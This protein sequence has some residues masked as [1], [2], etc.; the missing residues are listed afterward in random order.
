MKHRVLLSAAGLC[1]AVHSCTELPLPDGNGTVEIILRSPSAGTDTK[2]EDPS[3]DGITDANVF[4][5]NREE[6]LESSTYLSPG[7]FRYKDGEAALL[8][9][10][11]RTY[12]LTIAV[13]ANFGG[14]I[15]GITTL[16]DLKNKKMYLAYPDEYRGGIPMSGLLE[17]A[18]PDTLGRLTVRL[19][20]LMGRAGVRIDRS[21]L[22]AGISV[23]ASSLTA[24][25]SP[26]SASAFSPSSI[27]NI[28]EAFTTGFMKSG[29]GIMPLNTDERPGL[30]HEVWI[31]ALEN[32]H[33]DSPSVRS[34]CTYLELKLDYFSSG[35]VSAPGKYLIFRRFIGNGE[36]NCDLRRGYSYHYV[37]KLS[38]DGLTAEGWEADTS[39]L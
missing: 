16:D 5:F 4:V 33:G 36:D 37:L 39:Q 14:R 15:T 30:S 8:I 23:N 7:Q 31:Y 25:N 34:G 1:I 6:E 28:P 38:P 29:A 22:D 19:V 21:A 35:K 27:L 20:R 11:F 32:L 13:C 9:R 26:R 3:T 18:T 17:N 12:P 24:V 10:T 2:S